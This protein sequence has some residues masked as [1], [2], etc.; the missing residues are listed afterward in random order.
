MLFS[1]SLFRAHTHNTLLSLSRACVFVL[2][3]RV[4]EIERP[5]LEKLSNLFT[6]TKVNSKN[7]WCHEGQEAKTLG[8]VLV[9][10]LAVQ[11]ESDE[12]PTHY[13]HPGDIIGERELC[14]HRVRN[15]SMH[16]LEPEPCVIAE[17]EYDEFIRF[18]EGLGL[19]RAKSICQIIAVSLLEHVKR[20]KVR[21]EE[22]DRHKL[23]SIGNSRRG[24]FCNTVT[25]VMSSNDLKKESSFYA[26][27]HAST[28]SE[29]Y[30]GVIDGLIERCTVPIA[31]EL[32]REIIHDYNNTLQDVFERNLIFVTMEEKLA[33]QIR[34]C[35]HIV[36]VKAGDILMATGD[37]CEAFF[38]VHTGEIG[39]YIENEF[40][41]AF[42]L[43]GNHSLA[44][45]AVQKTQVH[46][47]IVRHT[48]SL[49]EKRPHE[50]A[51]TEEDLPYDFTSEQTAL[52]LSK[53]NTIRQP[54]IPTPIS[55]SPVV[56]FSV[57]EK[58]TQAKPEKWPVIQFTQ[59]L[60][61]TVKCSDS[62]GAI[63]VRRKKLNQNSAEK[64]KS[65]RYKTVALAQI[66][67]RGAS[68]GNNAL[69]SGDPSDLTLCALCD[70]T[71]LVIG[72]E[73]FAEL[74]LQYDQ[75][76][77]YTLKTLLERTPYACHLSAE[78]VCNLVDAVTLR[79]YSDGD[80]I[81]SNDDVMNEECFTVLTGCVAQ[82]KPGNTLMPTVGK[83]TSLT[84]F[85]DKPYLNSF[86]DVVSAAIPSI[87]RQPSITRAASN[88][89]TH[90]GMKILKQFNE[91]DTFAEY[92]LED[93]KF[94]LDVS[95]V[96]IRCER[97][98]FLVCL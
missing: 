81:V 3:L 64:V 98:L 45:G 9:G 73:R 34:K 22:L 65:E 46:P 79:N 55:A 77:V 87:L 68:F 88:V 12:D 5:L 71:L 20:E 39:V 1:F 35:F 36:Q 82:V 40:S 80:V 97:P 6:E 78:A 50:L 23:Q 74:R 27:S 49:S 75:K 76:R 52:S 29:S 67:T 85:E 48:G 47:N 13:Y 93:L 53:R 15:D 31:K 19:K 33:K 90:A 59:M 28:H 58:R 69:V 91:G 95:K 24:A 62:S 14:G 63:Q 18:I 84:T 92:A 41:K 54:S 11:N 60:L 66:V 8:I 4:T 57:L 96:S 17:I 72:R 94:D 32:N 10:Q 25:S 43:H 26:I 37:N 83:T 51:S 16:A 56:K 44:S 30:D 42:S 2:Y 70:S 21:Q 61:P 7:H 89:R 38:V 86:E